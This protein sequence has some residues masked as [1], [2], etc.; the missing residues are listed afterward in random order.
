MKKEDIAPL[1]TRQIKE[2]VR[3]YESIAV[4]QEAGVTNFI[5]IGPGKVLSGFV[6]KIDKRAKL[7]TVEDQASLEA[8]LGN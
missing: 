6:K 7:A 3:F 2:P 8:L 4:M 5:E 1:L